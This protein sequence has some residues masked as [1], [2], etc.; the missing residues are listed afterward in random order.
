MNLICRK[1]GFRLTSDDVKCKC[2]G[3]P[4]SEVAVDRDTLYANRSQ[5]PAYAPAPTPTP[6]PAPAPVQ[7]IKR[8]NTA[9]AVGSAPTMISKPSFGAKDSGGSI[10]ASFDWETNWSERRMRGG[11][12]GIILTDTSNLGNASGFFSALS[13][14]VA[15][16]SALGIDYCLLDLKDQRVV[17]TVSMDMDG[18]VGLLD[19]IYDVA[20]PDYLLI[21]GDATVIP[22]AD[23][24]NE[25]DDGDETVPSDLPY[26][27][28]DTTSPWEGMIY[29]FNNVTQVGRIPA[30]VSNGFAEAISY[31]NNTRLF[32]G[33]R[34]VNAFAY[35]A[36]VWENTSSAEFR[37]LS[38]HLITSPAY[39]CDRGLAATGMYTQL[40]EL[41]GAYNLL[42]F[43]L[44]GSDATH[45]WYGQSGQSYP[46]AFVKELLPN[47]NGYALCTEACYG[48]RP[49][50]SASIV[51]GA[52]MNG[53]V[54]YVGSSRIAYGMSNGSMSC[55]DIIANSFTSGI[56]R[57]ST[58][59]NAFLMAL[60]AISSRGAMDE[61]EIKTLA[62]FALYGDPS[63]ALINPTF[64]VEA[65]RPSAKK[66]KTAQKDSSR[67]IRLVNCE[68]GRSAKGASVSFTAEEKVRIES[69]LCRIN[70]NQNKF[71]LE[72]TSAAQTVKPKV[73]KVMG[74]EEYRAV[75]ASATGNIKSV[76]K[77][78]L[79][80]NGNVKKVYNSK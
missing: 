19:L 1:C 40:G 18:M 41:D 55:A 80:S 26:V 38:P 68:S 61:E 3:C 60:S 74:R 77:M 54:S 23:W 46:D 67:A 20:V 62:E 28:L 75:Y 36:K 63:V 29:D 13:D 45:T 27:T 53:C 16:K 51:V 4:A 14:Y 15:H 31:F 24:Y 79:D 49:L 35:S 50:A 7:P 48:A 5:S 39:T 72:G 8:Y 58:A 22:Q 17:S 2:C 71:V 65:S 70:E 34:A 64:R 52:L 78:H 76:V 42:C 69:V 57:G 9:P 59:G 21:V 73:Y 10:F 30:K 11:Q 6:T 33:Y 12:V 37:H 32:S 47:N 43:N 44:H 56:A 66:K 25:C